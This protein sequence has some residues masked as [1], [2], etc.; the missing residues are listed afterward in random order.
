MVKYSPQEA[1]FWQAM[2]MWANG[3]PYYMAC[4]ICNKYMSAKSKNGQNHFFGR[5]HPDKNI[6]EIFSPVPIDTTTYV[7]D[8]RGGVKPMREEEYLK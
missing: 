7:R 6:Y 8:G 2:L 3:S 4:N 1:D 5:A